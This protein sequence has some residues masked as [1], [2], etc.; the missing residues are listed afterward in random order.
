[1]L[2]CELTINA[3][4]YLF[5]ASYSERPARQPDLCRRSNVQMKNSQKKNYISTEIHSTKY[6]R[7]N[8]WKVCLPK[9]IH[10]VLPCV[11][12]ASGNLTTGSW[13]VIYSK[14]LLQNRCLDRNITLVFHLIKLYNTLFL[15]L[16][17]SKEFLWNINLPKF[18]NALGGLDACIWCV[19][20]PRTEN[21]ILSYVNYT[22]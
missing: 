5:T 1:M 11:S 9:H 2:T 15:F 4:N 7:V 19:W 21:Q 20:T 16:Y 12:E 18:F 13:I 3:I 14:I 22:L 6:Q 10:V 17:R 8:I